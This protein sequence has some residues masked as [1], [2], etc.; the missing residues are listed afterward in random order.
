[1]RVDV[2]AS[3]AAQRESLGQR[4]RLQATRNCGRTPTFVVSHAETGEVWL[5]EAR[6]P[7]EQ[8]SRLL[9]RAGFHPDVKLEYKGM[10]CPIGVWGAEIYPP[11]YHSSA[12][13]AMKAYAPNRSPVGERALLLEWYSNG[14]LVDRDAAPF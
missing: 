7:L 1:M 9:L 5:D 8:A 14:A 2:L 13:R 12:S 3:V 6:F 4:I 10:L 11:P